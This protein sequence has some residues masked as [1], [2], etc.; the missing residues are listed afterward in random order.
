M[1]S[2][3]AFTCLTAGSFFLRT[4]MTVAE[5]NLRTRTISRT[6]LPL[7][8]ISMICCFTA[9]SRPLSWYC[10]GENGARTGAIVT[11]IVLG[12]IGLFPVLHHISTVTIRAL[13]LHKSHRMSPTKSCGICSNARSWFVNLL[14]D[15]GSGQWERHVI[16]SAVFG[17]NFCHFSS[18]VALGKASASRHGGVAGPCGR[19]SGVWGV[20]R[21]RTRVTLGRIRRNDGVGLLETIQERFEELAHGRQGIVIKKRVYPFPQQAFTPQLRPYRLKQGATELLGLIH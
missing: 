1:W 10:K 16:L 3:L 4:V 19:V 18:Q 6:P 9:G 15:H 17:S 13:H 12:A 7:S 5:L 20:R 14:Y 2:S 8:V 11:A 21:R